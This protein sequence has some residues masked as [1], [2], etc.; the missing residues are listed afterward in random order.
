MLVILL[1]LTIVLVVVLTLVL[2][3]V[4]M[5]VLNEHKYEHCSCFTLDSH[6]AAA[7]GRTDGEG[8]GG[9]G[10]A[11]GETWSLGSFF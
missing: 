9:E 8:A 5:L 1:V 6:I 11:G 7:A 4:L 2:M 10:R 3:L